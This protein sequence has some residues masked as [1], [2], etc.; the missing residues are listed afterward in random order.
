MDKKQEVDSAPNRLIETLENARKLEIALQPIVVN[1][2][3]KNIDGDSVKQLVGDI[4]D[5]SN[6]IKALAQYI[7]I[8]DVEK[9]STDERE[10]LIADY[11]ITRDVL[12]S[13]FKNSGDTFKLGTVEQVVSSLAGSYSNRT[14]RT[15]PTRL[16]NKAS[17][18]GV[19][20]VIGTIEQL[21]K[22]LG[23]EPAAKGILARL[24][25]LKEPR[26]VG[27]LL[28]PFYEGA[29]GQFRGAT[30]NAY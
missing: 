1:Y 24:K 19:Q 3:G 22:T 13:S 14:L 11:G 4:Y 10:K 25:N 26:E 15:E 8:K 12:E 18:E 27:E 20:S 21:V 30:T 29:Y 6:F 9:L 2:I 16:Q 7:G 28:G 17:K 23:G 5:S